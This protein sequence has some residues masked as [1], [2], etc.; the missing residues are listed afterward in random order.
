MSAS[1]CPSADQISR[2]LV[3][4]LDQNDI[5]E[6]ATH[7]AAC[8]S[9]QARA[10]Q[11]E[12]RTADPLVDE[13]RGRQSPADSFEDES[14]YSDALKGIKAIGRQ[15]AFISS[16]KSCLVDEPA[17]EEL[18]DYRILEKIGQGGMGAVYKALHT[19]LDKVVAIKVLP[20]DRMRDEHA[21]ERFD[22]EMKAV[23]RLE[24]PNIVQARD[25]GETDGRHYLVMEYVAGVDL[26]SLVA[27]YGPLPIAEACALVRQAA[28]GLQFV[29][30]N[31]MVH[32]DI[33]PSNLMVTHEAQVKILDLGLALLHESKKGTGPICRN[34]PEGAAHK[35]E[36]S[37]FSTQLTSA[38]QIM[39]TLDYMAPEQCDDSHQVDI[40]AD[41]YSLGA[42]LYKL[43]VG[44]GPFEEDRLDTPI[45]KMMA[46]TG[47]P[48]P[49]I[50]KLRAD[51]PRPLVQVVTRMLA[52][53]PD[54]R[55]AT[56]AE[57][58]TALAPW[59][60]SHDLNGW[61]AAALDQPLDT[62]KTE[63]LMSVDDADT[64]PE[65]ATTDRGDAFDPYHKWLSIPPEEQPPHHYRLL[66]L[67]LFE[68]DP[69]VIEMAADRQM[70]HV[71][72]FQSGKHSGAS[73]NVLNQIS[74]AKVTL[75]NAAKRAAYDEKL[76][77]QLA[78]RKPKRAAAK[79]EPT[80]AIKTAAAI[81]P[82]NAAA[83]SFAAAQPTAAL[84]PTVVAAGSANETPFVMQPIVWAAAALVAVVLV[85]GVAFV[86]TRGNDP[87]VAESPISTL[88][89]DHDRGKNIAEPA[90]A[91]SL[92]TQEEQ[93][94]PETAN[95]D[96]ADQT[97]SSSRTAE[98]SSVSASQSAPVKITR[99]PSADNSSA[100]DLFADTSSVPAASRAGAQAPGAIGPEQSI[101]VLP[102]ISPGRDTVSGQWNWSD[103][104]LTIEQPEGQAQLTVPVEI[105]GG[106][107][108]TI[109]AE[110]PAGE[111]L[112]VGL[113][114]RD[115]YV[116]L[117]I[118][119]NQAGTKG[120]GGAGL[121]N[122][123]GQPFAD[124]SSHSPL[125]QFENKQ[126][127]TI[128]I[129]VAFEFDNASVT[130][131]FD[132]RAPM[133][134]QKLPLRNFSADP[135]FP[136]ANAKAPFLGVRNATFVFHKVELKML[137]GRA[138]PL[139][140]DGAV[141]SHTPA[142]DS[143][144]GA[145]STV[146]AS[147][148]AASSV[149]APPAQPVDLIQV[150]LRKYLREQIHPFKAGGDWFIQNDVLMCR[151]AD[152]FARVDTWY[153]P[154]GDYRLT[155][156]FVR[157]SGGESVV[158]ILPCAASSV[159]MAL[160]SSLG[161]QLHV[162]DGK[163]F[164][165]ANP[166]RTTEFKLV[167][168]LEY[169]A[170]AEVRLRDGQADIQVNVNGQPVVS[171]RGA[172]SQLSISE[173]WRMPD[174]TRIGVG[175][176]GILV[177]FKSLVVELLPRRDGALAGFDSA[178]RLPIPDAAAREKAARQVDAIFGEQ[179][180][181]ADTPVAKANV[182]KE[183]IATAAKSP[184]DPPSQFA[185]LFKAWEIGVDAADGETIKLAME[186]MARRFDVDTIK[187]RGRGLVTAAKA[188]GLTTAQEKKL[189]LA[190]LDL[191][192]DATE[193]DRFDIAGS[194][195]DA[196]KNRATATR[197]NEF[198]RQTKERIDRGRDL[199]RM[200]KA[201]AEAAALLDKQPDDEKANLLVGQYK[202]Y[203]KLDW[204]GG[205]PHLA[206]CGD[207]ALAKLAQQDLA[208]PASAAE[209][210]KLAD[211]WWESAEAER[212]DY[213]K[214]A[215]FARAAAWYRTA[216]E[217][218]TGLLQ[219]QAEKR[220]ATYAE[221]SG[222]QAA[223]GGLPAG[224]ER[225][226]P[227]APAGPIAFVPAG[228]I[229]TPDDFQFGVVY[230]RD[231]KLIAAGMRDFSMVWSAETGKLVGKYN[232]PNIPSG[233]R[234]GVV[235]VAFSPDGKT[236][237]TSGYGPNILL[238]DVASGKMRGDL[239]SAGEWIMGL[240]FS[241][242]GSVLASAAREQAIRLWDGATGNQRK[243][244]RGYYAGTLNVAFSPNG[245]LLA[246]TGSDGLLTVHS[247]KDGQ[248]IAHPRISHVKTNA[249]AW[250]PAGTLLATGSESMDV[251]VFNAQTFEKVAQLKGHAAAVSAVAF[252]PATAPAPM[253]VS[254]DQQ[255]YIRVWNPAT[256]KEVFLFKAPSANVTG[257]A[258]SPDGKHLA[259]CG[260]G[261][262]ITIWEIRV[263]RSRR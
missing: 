89:D 74:A 191:C 67:K 221:I 145:T 165:D 130:V 226:K 107:E 232:V 12:S 62:I 209:Q 6:V 154:V 88:P 222:G 244:F 21:V 68:A 197:D 132:D 196:A 25:A 187:E 46:L 237:A 121:S 261:E 219:I 163:Q 27:K 128:R 248:R 255:S 123:R 42:T 116:S 129:V 218:A 39:G 186:A 90:I 155:A 254:A 135:D 136:P 168:G 118:D 242:D 195:W 63:N 152:E 47:E 193:S 93:P 224:S 184:E 92:K 204:P 95:R 48:I 122:L 22:R 55:F 198:I 100:D 110:K 35:L 142:E 98:P 83:P 227:E 82:A 236:L 106:Y 157:V 111:S 257:L 126:R 65:Q 159:T 124:N 127:H 201:A 49:A 1:M 253:L 144:T 220:L 77:V 228:Q 2:Y 140:G 258:F 81:E 117:V 57:V 206:M 230:S 73:Q 41:I 203:I 94:L 171:F 194:V 37:P 75:I 147:P 61:L 251:D 99:Q 172:Q 199:E 173:K 112:H 60:E 133:I 29:H 151:K 177:N 247:M 115:H 138:T 225:A 238:F 214:Q 215:Q 16:K 146:A 213:V 212:V 5:D 182:A 17:L 235:A 33:K 208:G 104:Q 164:N 32:R 87:L 3:G 11:L 120:R 79:P 14:T 131:K 143:P 169:T 66:G 86:A 239:K 263:K 28:E 20:A 80:S 19:R 185:L 43:L 188:R 246:S 76:K 71:R 7:V 262:S 96:A 240:D 161:N 56:P 170:V 30:Q 8:S 245:Q 4:M 250:S 183:L 179:I 119:S 45:K 34:G 44:R 178:T 24:H 149:P 108:L 54:R 78:A 102:L 109:D 114:L 141:A 101:D 58:A 51:V 148:V 134:Y 167:N 84:K 207:A 181:A 125:R 64:N 23:G 103:G 234:A 9:C 259:T 72:T 15:P 249:I 180:A 241:P 243:E 158:L 252:A 105:V 211:A 36:P 190:M 139:T 18:R 69:E 229:P 53:D 202:C 160:G 153:S 156:K 189:V 113:P 256:A 59:A 166:T 10:D 223:P 175:A 210:V 52:R 26:S 233:R 50:Q 97:V 192:D 40:R 216:L 137:D 200:Y 205:L 150:I 231:G 85:G 162:V 70:A 176:H 217:Q 174:A 38:G 260:S 91:S 13:L 31:G